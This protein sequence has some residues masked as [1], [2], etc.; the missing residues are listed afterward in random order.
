MLS[1]NTGNHIHHKTLQGWLEEYSRVL[2]DDRVLLAWKLDVEINKTDAAGHYLIDV[3]PMHMDEWE[4]TENYA[5]F[6]G[7]SHVLLDQESASKV[8]SLSVEYV[9][10]MMAHV[11]F[12]SHLV[13]EIL[14]NKPA[15][16]SHP[17][18]KQM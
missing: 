2:Q 7:W 13:D 9:A 16:N 11:D 18:S 8:D 14:R 4:A 10:S 12:E 3:K 5:D 17:L 6:A 15:G 1:L